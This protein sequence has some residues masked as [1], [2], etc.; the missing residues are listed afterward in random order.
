VLLG[1]S[2]GSIGDETED[3]GATGA[4]E[5]MALLGALGNG[6][7]GGIDGA[8]GLVTTDGAVLTGRVRRNCGAADA[9]PGI[10]SVGEAIGDDTG[11]IGA[12]AAASTGASGAGRTGAVANCTG[13]ASGEGATSG[14]IVAGCGIG[15]GSV[16]VTGL[17]GRGGSNSDVRVG[18]R[19]YRF[20]QGHP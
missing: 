20:G 13:G 14:G 15:A 6:S 17:A 3:G 7:A 11:S 9:E 8:T 4:S 5:G 12:A 10:G 16:E 18:T 19:I 1:G 2:T